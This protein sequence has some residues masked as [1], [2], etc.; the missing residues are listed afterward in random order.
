MR[1]VE[2]SIIVGVLGQ[3]AS[4]KSTAARTL[5]EHLGGEGQVAF[6][7]DAVLL[8]SQA[9]N[10]ILE[11]EDSGVILCVEEDGRQRLECEHA[12]VWLPP[13]EDFQTVELA[14]L[15][16]DVDDGVLPEWLHRARIELGHE[17]RRRST[18]GKPIIVEAG[19]GEFPARHTIAD[20]FG[21]LQEAGVDPRQVKWIIVEAG[22]DK[23]SERNERQRFGPLVDVFARIAAD[24]GDLDPKL[25]DR[26][27]EE[28]T[29]IRR[30]RNDHDDI[31][32]FRD[33]VVS[34]YDEMFAGR[35]SAQS[36]RQRR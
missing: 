6:L 20:L 8:A 33:D 9:V 12:T 14:T 16:F 25:Q 13:G 15:R 27:I 32:R 1:E 2:G 11:P 36:L 31:A 29:V 10:H 5:V 22:F 3:W 21:A 30:V 24:G 18:E 17:I 7:N 34:A 19:F 35:L 4:G 26:L 23:R 28:G